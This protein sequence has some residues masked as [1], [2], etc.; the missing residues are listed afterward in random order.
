MAD[1]DRLSA[2]DQTGQRAKR[3]VV[4]TKRAV[5]DTRDKPDGVCE[6]HDRLIVSS[7][8]VDLAV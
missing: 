2:P 5:L 4:E 8:W 7:V 1:D 3:E 6:H